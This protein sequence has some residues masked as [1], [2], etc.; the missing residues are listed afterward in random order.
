VI[1][2][3]LLQATGSR[4]ISRSGTAIAALVASGMFTMISAWTDSAT[5]FSMTIAVGALFSGM[6]GPAT[7]A[8]TIDIGGRDTAVVMAVMNMAGCLSTAIL[9]TILGIW[10]DQLR[11]TGGNWDLVVYLHAAFSFA[12]A[13]SWIVVNPNRAIS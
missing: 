4:W 8:A 13:L 1:V 7:W 2:D 5:Q 11:A 10:F 6:A 12:A 3:W 9:P